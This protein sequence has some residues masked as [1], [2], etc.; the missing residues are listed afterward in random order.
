M[1][2]TYYT[3][4]ERDA[5]AS[6]AIRDQA[7]KIDKL[8]RFLCETLVQWENGGQVDPSEELFEWWE[9]HK[10]HD[11]ELLKA[12]KAKEKAERAKRAAER[13]KEREIEQALY[14]KLHK[15]YGKK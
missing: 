8:T 6:K 14:E 13:K 3:E 2:C 11:A 4:A 15:K 10:R 5:M 9:D 1:P 7:V 12:Q